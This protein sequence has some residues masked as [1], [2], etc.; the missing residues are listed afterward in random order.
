MQ[1]NSSGFAPHIELACDDFAA[2]WKYPDPT[3]LSL[4]LS[5]PKILLILLIL[6]KN[7]PLCGLPSPLAREDV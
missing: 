5:M 6:S 1:E 7:S 3:L 4:L 2:L